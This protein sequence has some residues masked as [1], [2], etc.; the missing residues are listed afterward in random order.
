MGT[1]ERIKGS[2]NTT[3]RRGRK[4][5]PTSESERIGR[6]GRNGLIETRKSSLEYSGKGVF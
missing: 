2:H 3:K 4:T 5:C 6:T 1:G